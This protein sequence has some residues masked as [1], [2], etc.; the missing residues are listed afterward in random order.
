MSARRVCDLAVDD[1]RR[2]LES[3]AGKDV[4]LRYSGYRDAATA[5][6]LTGRFVCVASAITGGQSDVVIVQ[7]HGRHPLAFSAATILAVELVA[8]PVR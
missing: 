5:K 4:T 3:F 8:E 7:P 1:R 2:L 6:E